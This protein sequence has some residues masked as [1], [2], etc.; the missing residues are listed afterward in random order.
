MA[1]QLPGSL[2]WKV[3]RQL[4]RQLHGLLDVFQQ[5]D[6]QKTTS[7]GVGRRFG[8]LLRQAAKLEELGYPVPAEALRQYLVEHYEGGHLSGKV[9]LFKKAKEPY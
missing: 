1:T 5:I 9:C 8:T 2:R 6:K 7:T 4:A 3:R